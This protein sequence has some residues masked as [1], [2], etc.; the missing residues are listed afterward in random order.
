MLEQPG[1]KVNAQSHIPCNRPRQGATALIIAAARGFDDIVKLLLDQPGID[2]SIRTDDGDGMRTALELAR[3]HH[4]ENCVEL[5]S[6]TPRN[7]TNE[8]D[9]KDKPK[10]TGNTIGATESWK[11]FISIK[12]IWCQKPYWHI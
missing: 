6:D 12:R 2:K 10:K 3:M 9:H 11:F 7:E 8:E 5:L 4:H 1:I